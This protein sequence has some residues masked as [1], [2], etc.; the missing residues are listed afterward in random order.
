MDHFFR[1]ELGRLHAVLTRLVGPDNLSLVEDVAQGA[2]LRAMRTWSIGGIPPNPSAWITRVAIN[3]ARDA[4]RRQRMAAG[5]E[6]AI[7]TYLEQVRPDTSSGADENGLGDATLRLMFVCCHP[8]LGADA[9]V[10]LAL[11]MLCGFSTAEIARAFLSSES[12]IEKQ[13]T[14]TKQRIRD[15]GIRFEIPDAPELGDRIE[16]ILA[17]LYLL[18]NEGYKASE[19]DQLVRVELCQEALRLAHELAAHPAGDTPR[20]H[21]L[22]ALMY[23]T[24]A[25][26]PARIDP[27]G[28][29]LRLDVQDRSKWDQELIDRGLAEIAQASRGDT[30]SEYHLQAGIAACHC[31]APDYASTDWPRIVCHYDALYRLKPSPVVALNRAVAVAHASGPQAGLDALARIPEPEKL[32]TYYLAHAVAGELHWRLGQDHAA[33]ERFRKALRLARVGPEQRHLSRLLDQVG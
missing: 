14:R 30:V 10:V 26:T 19:G 5:K 15:S 3:L 21:A 22:L 4:L 11:K 23:L 28:T 12:A 1:H 24:A 9:Q 29:L 20:T 18:F 16:G 33:A 8:A 7:L 31:I 25:R 6:P 13:L 27:D 2:L 17:T 32:D